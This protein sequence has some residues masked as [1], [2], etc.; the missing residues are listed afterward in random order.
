MPRRQSRSARASTRRSL[1]RSANVMSLSDSTRCRHLD[2]L[3]TS[4]YARCG[5]FRAL[6]RRLYEQGIS[7]F[8]S[9]EG[10]NQFRQQ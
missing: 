10:K 4:C 2:Q 5:G 9:V 1:R 6:S 3:W 7:F 8:S